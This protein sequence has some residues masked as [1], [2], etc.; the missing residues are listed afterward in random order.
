MAMGV[1]GGGWFGIGF[2]GMKWTLMPVKSN[3]WML[4]FPTVSY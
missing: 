1:V 2:L 3:V 4:G